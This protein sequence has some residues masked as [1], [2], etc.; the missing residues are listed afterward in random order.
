M[1]PFTPV[2]RDIEMYRV[3]SKKSAYGLYLRG[4]ANAPIENIRVV[5][6][7]FEFRQPADS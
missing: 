3:T 2:A 4:F 1:G 7:H 6:C 5:D